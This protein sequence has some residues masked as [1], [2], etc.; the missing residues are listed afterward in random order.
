MSWCLLILAGCGG[1]TS[2]PTAPDSG[3]QSPVLSTRPA[4]L[5]PVLY[6]MFAASADVPE[7]AANGGNVVLIVPSYA[8][9][10]QAVAGA[11]RANGKVAILSAHHVFGG[12]EATWEAG[13]AQT[14]KWAE[15]FREMI[16]AVYVVDEP[17]GNGISKAT[18]DRAIAR[19]KA[20][21]YKTMVADNV[22]WGL[23]HGRAPSD[24][25][26]VTCYDW[27]GPGSW[28]LDRCREAYRTHPEW[29]VAIGQGFNWHHRSGSPYDQVRAWTE[30][31]RQRQGVV[32]WVAR[33]PGQTGILDDPEALAAYHAGAGW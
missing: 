10:A 3:T 6:G 13:W 9:D 11:L 28:S 5:P 4:E 31:G 23:I 25:F 16:G 30:I 27:P 2:S 19:V 24:Y 29:N 14:L 22:E 20:D 33:W 18:R 8:D 15:P 1:S 26:G 7:A 12:H 21:G 32:F 17:I